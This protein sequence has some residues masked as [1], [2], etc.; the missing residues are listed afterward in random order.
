MAIS[1]RQYNMSSG[2]ITARD[3][4]GE[5]AEH[6]LIVDDDVVCVQTLHAV[7]KDLG[8]VAFT[9]RATEVL[10]LAKRL[11]PSVVLLDISMP[12][13]DGYQLC[14]D[15]KSCPE[16][17]DAAIIFITSNGDVDHE[18]KAFEVGASDFV[19]KPFNIQLV[20]ARVQVQL[21]LRREQRRLWSTQRDLA[22]VI[23]NVPGHITFW[24]SDLR[25]QLCSDQDGRWFGVPPGGFAGAP[26]R[27]VLAEELAHSVH[28]LLERLLHQAGRD[29]SPADA[30]IALSYRATDGSKR[31]I[32][33]SA[34]LRLDAKN[35]WGALL[36]LTDV[37]AVSAAEAALGEERER[38]QVILSSIGDSVIA[39]DALGRITYM[40]PVAETMTEWAMED[41]LGQP[42]ES[43]MPL[44]S[45]GEEVTLQNPIRIALVQQRTVGMA[46]DTLLV[47]RNGHRVPVEDSASPIRDAEG[48]I[49]GAVIVFH[50]VSETRAMAIKMTHLAQHDQ[51]TDLPNRLLL[52]DRISQAMRSAVA[53]HGSLA[54]MI[55]DLDHFK[56]VNDSHGHHIGD[57]ILRTVADRL[58]AT[59]SSDATVSRQGGDEF[60]ILLPEIQSPEQ[61][62]L[63]AQAA[64]DGVS[65]TIIIEGTDFHVGCSVGI[66]V[67]PDDALTR[68]DLMRHAD[69]ALYRA[70]SD[71]RNRYSFHSASIEHMLMQRSR[72]GKTLRAAIDN[73]RVEVHYQ[74]QVEVPS[75]R[76]DTVEA[77]VRL[78]DESGE[79]IAPSEF[80]A[81]AEETGLIVAL[82]RAVL[83]DACK[84]IK[85]ARALGHN[86]HVAINVSIVQ[87]AQPDYLESLCELCAAHGVNPECIELEITE[88]Q[89][90]RDAD[91]M[92]H[93]LDRLRQHGFRVALDDFGTGYSSL[94]YL[95]Q[96][97]VDVLK[98][99]KSFVSQLATSHQS[100]SIASAIIQLGKSLQMG[101][102]AE[103]V[104]TQGQVDQLLG[105]GC[106]T[107]QG[108]FYSKPMAADA[109]LV[110][111]EQRKQTQPS[112]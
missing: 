54:L 31:H 58:T 79:L 90:M 96:L 21:A 108:Y 20:R 37:T 43:V 73:G 10:S 56:F 91:N 23:K 94:A 33:A 105:M 8:T 85:N 45:H 44:R 18:L 66:S 55:L 17:Q 16:T 65:S 15:L 24:D 112:V 19:P 101:L 109:L 81:Y 87:F 82:G 75:L 46:L 103:G 36:L 42:I 74:P 89:L 95:S 5:Q 64:I 3:H 111:L 60:M 97:P 7:V 70:K 83:L 48:N 102:I 93:L 12:D 104:E 27:A 84:Q 57:L 22:D 53:A 51:L 99:D 32:H 61:A 47:T 77:L 80:I 50:D 4:H 78:R 25:C 34:V 98:I 107:M 28:T 86:L 67:Y 2:A 69:S 6:I 14:A 26:V 35:A 88:G 38:A 68:E 52:A 76:V 30:S 100:V 40:N 1:E 13:R 39:T 110:W 72:T 41:A 71:G 62:R 9:T 59:F 11:K 63:L 49:V 92:K 106:N 29:K